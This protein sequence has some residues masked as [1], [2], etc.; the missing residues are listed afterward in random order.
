MLIHRV[1]SL[2]FENLLQGHTKL[3]MLVLS[4]CL[5]VY[6]CAMYVEYLQRPERTLDLLGLEL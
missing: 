6:L 4:V 3:P 2:T 5:N 1:I